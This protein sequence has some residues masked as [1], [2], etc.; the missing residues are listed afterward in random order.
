MR[1]QHFFLDI[2][3]SFDNAWHDAI[4]G[5]FGAMHCPP[6]ITVKPLP[7]YD[8][9]LTIEIE[10]GCPQGSTLSPFLWNILLDEALRLKLPPGVKI[11]TY[12]DNL[13]VFNYGLNGAAMK[14]VSQSAY[15]NLVDWVK[16]V[17]LV[18]CMARN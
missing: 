9:E 1:I 7:L 12:A 3:C 13:V 17:K 16:T 4:I 8:T 11:Q 14:T 15:D 5:N 6:H 18:I 10:K 2:N